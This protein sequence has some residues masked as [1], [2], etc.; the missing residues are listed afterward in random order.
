MSRNPVIPFVLIMV[1]GIALVF[2]LS[3]KGLGDAEKVAQGGKEG[4]EQTEQTASSPEEIYKASCIGCH[5]GNYE[6][7]VGPA[8]TGV[9]G[10]LSTDEMKE[11]LINGKGSMPPGLVKEDQADEM[12]EWLSSL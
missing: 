3:L 2:G 11:I 4:E 7:G 5:G 8:L 9:G 1:M 12:A 6:G 10:K